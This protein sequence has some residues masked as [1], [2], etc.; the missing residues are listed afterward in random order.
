MLHS[1]RSFFMVDGWRFESSETRRGK[2]PFSMVKYVLEGHR[3]HRRILPHESGVSPT[4][5]CPNILPDTS[6]EG[7][8]RVPPAQPADEA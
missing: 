5:R 6:D 4:N 2:A 3:A 1:L 8:A 7:T